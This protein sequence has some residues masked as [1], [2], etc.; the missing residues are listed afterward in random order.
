M[1]RKYYITAEENPNI[2]K[3]QFNINSKRSYSLDFSPWAE[4]NNN[5]SS[6][7]W[8]VKTGQASITS[9]TL[10][11]NVVTANI[12]ATQEGRNIIE[13]LADTGTEKYS[14]YLDLYVRDPNK[15]NNEYF[16]DYI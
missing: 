1:T 3:D 2:V 5:L 14:T 15:V 13:I 9:E 4:D 7:T 8:T 6:V 16:Y 10:S 11:S 12:E